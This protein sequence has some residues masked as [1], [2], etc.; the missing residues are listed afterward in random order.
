MP[1]IEKDPWRLQY[2]EGIP[3]PENVI[4]PTDDDVAYR[5]YPQYRWVYNKLLTCETQGLEN[6]PHGTTPSHFPVFSKPVYNLRGMGTDSKIISTPEEYE[7]KQTPGHMWMPLLEGEHVS[8]DVAVISGKPVWWRHTIGISLG[9]GTF[10]Y[11][12]VSDESRNDIESYCGDWACR[13]LTEYTGIVNF[14]TI[15][16]TIIEC[17]LRLSDQ[18]VDLYGP[19]WV[20]S[21]INLYINKVWNFKDDSRR[22]GYSVVLFGKHGVRYSRI[23]S[24]TIKELMNTPGVSSIQIT[25]HEEKS[26]RSHAMPP[27]GFRLAIV[28]CWLLDSGFKVRERLASLFQLT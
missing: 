22:K 26:L 19:G 23:D 15:S 11:W 8:S 20:E 3:C 18:F 1:I 7:E 28:N 25:F 21:V 5:L 10:D 16:G 17:H 9:E 6:G 4:I 2:F 14:E 27:G 24:S 13:N 12:A